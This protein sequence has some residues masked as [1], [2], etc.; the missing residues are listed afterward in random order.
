ML[1]ESCGEYESNVHLEHVINGVSREVNLCEECAVKSGININGSMSLTD[2]LVG[3]GALEEVEG[4]GS[5]KACPFCH[6]TVSE[7]RKT[8]RLGCAVCYD[9]FNAELKTLLAGMQKSAK[10][11]GKVPSSGAGPTPKNDRLSAL[12]KELSEAVAGEDFEKAA[13][14]RDEIRES[15]PVDKPAGKALE[16]K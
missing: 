9:V 14:I 16:T 6:M 13:R 8:S 3:L 1:C 2:I 11:V 12:E 15:R 5:E 4:G 7:F 10:H